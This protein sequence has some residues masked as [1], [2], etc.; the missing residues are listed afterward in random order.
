MA[1]GLI[2]HR[3]E[4]TLISQA[5]DGRVSLLTLLEQR[6]LSEMITRAQLGDHPPS[7]AAA[8]AAA[9]AAAGAAGAAAAGAAGA[10][11]VGRSAGIACRDL[12]LPGRH[13]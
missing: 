5:A 11:S 3:F 6:R 13:L 12:E 1:E 7:L 2:S 8:H 9:A 4:H 10:G